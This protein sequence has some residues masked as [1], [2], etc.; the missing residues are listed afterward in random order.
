MRVIC[1]HVCQYVHAGPWGL[2][3]FVCMPECVCGVCVF[4]TPKSAPSMHVNCHV[5]FVLSFR[6]TINDP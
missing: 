1:G 5:D 2:I 4:P 6:I 3:A